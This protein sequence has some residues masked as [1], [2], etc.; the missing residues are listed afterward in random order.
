MQLGLPLTTLAVVQIT[1]LAH[2]L[3]LSTPCSLLA[4][5]F[6]LPP[7]LVYLEG[8]EVIVTYVMEITRT[9]RCKALKIRTN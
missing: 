7:I 9:P 1:N 2:I 5:L 3:P 6:P 8:N 4:H